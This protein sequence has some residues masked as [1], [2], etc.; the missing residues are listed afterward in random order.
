MNLRSRFEA[1]FSPRRRWPDPDRPELARGGALGP[2]ELVVPRS[3]CVHRHQS[4]RDLPPKQRGAALAL[5][6]LRWAP[7]SASR[8]M[9]RWQEG[10]A[11]VWIWTP[12]E[13]AEPDAAAVLVPEASLRAAPASPDAERLVAMRE[14]V[15]GQVWRDG[16]LVASRW[17]PSAPEAPAWWQFLRSSGV[18]V[19]GRPEVPAVEDAPL[20]AMPWGQ[21]PSRF[22]WSPAQ[23]EAAFWRGALLLTVFVVGWQLCAAV[24]WGV[25]SAYQDARL[26]RLRTESAPLIAARER[27]EADRARIE[28]LSAQAGGPRDYLLLADVRSRLPAQ[29]RLITWF[30]DGGSL[31]LELQSAESDPRVFVQAF[32]GHPLLANV[33]INPLDAGRL[34]LDVDLDAAP[35]VAEGEAR[36]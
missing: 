34:Q 12:P 1:L 21:A 16:R 8:W 13:G 17:W 14:G 26:E 6:A 15:D 30:R 2:L 10:E 11:Q 28:A 7:T 19:E 36:P 29:A 33:T 23:L 27:A 25:A 3:E 5:A 18:G 32:R 35:T 24:V 22:R 4:F 31:R 9:A 20:L